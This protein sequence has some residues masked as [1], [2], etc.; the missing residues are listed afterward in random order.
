MKK[1]MTVV[2]LFAIFAIISSNMCQ[3]EKASVNLYAQNLPGG[4]VKIDTV[5]NI[6]SI[7]FAPSYPGCITAIGADSL[8]F[9]NTVFQYLPD[10]TK[11]YGVFSHPV[12]NY[13]PPNRIAFGFNNGTIPIC[14]FSKKPI[15]TI[16]FKVIGNI[17]SPILKY[18]QM[19][20][21]SIK[22]GDN[23]IAFR[24]ETA[25]LPIWVMVY[26]SFNWIIKSYQ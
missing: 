20:G 15:F 17:D 10:S 24:K 1:I 16:A 9:D 5:S 13:F 21:I 18:F 6:F 2:G 11:T 19:S 12:I 26:F 8:M 7:T 14:N 3:N 25:R 4:S 22:N 23:D